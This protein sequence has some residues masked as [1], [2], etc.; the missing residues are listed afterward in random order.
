MDT[1]EL[2][3]KKEISSGHLPAVPH[4]VIEPGITRSPLNLRELWRYRE[5]FY[6]LAWRDVKVRY[7][8]T[9]LGA[10]WAVIQ[11]L[12][13]MV[14][15]TLLFGE[16]ANIPSDGVPR[17]VFYF[18]ALVPWTY[19]STTINAAGMSLVVNSG[20]LSKIYF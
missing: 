11:P 7:K 9:A 1:V 19:L 18:T 17:P 8:Q 15:F 6:F 13:T 12:F 14:V 20:L 5:L 3:I 2:A 10:A 4:L 16:L